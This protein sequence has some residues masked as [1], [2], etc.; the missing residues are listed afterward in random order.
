MGT[1]NNKL[2]TQKFFIH[3]VILEISGHSRSNSDSDIANNLKLNTL[4]F[5]NTAINQKSTYKK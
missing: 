2:E 3:W 4:C 1:Q 5:T